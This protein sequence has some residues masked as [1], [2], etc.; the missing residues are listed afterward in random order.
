MGN[1][2]AA[3]STFI[4][5]ESANALPPT[6]FKLFLITTECT[7][8]IAELATPNETPIRETGVPSRNTP[9]K[10]PRVTMPHAK[11]ILR[12]GRA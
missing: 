9:I 5:H 11:K 2:T 3:L 4:Y 12:V 7:A 8:V 10:N 6:T 1:K